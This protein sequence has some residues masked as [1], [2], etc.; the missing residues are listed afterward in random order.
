MF[1]T[2]V[3]VT[4][5][6]DGEEATYLCDE[7]CSDCDCYHAPGPRAAQLAACDCDCHTWP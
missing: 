3:T 6:D 1:D 5:W 7:A 2:L 4:V